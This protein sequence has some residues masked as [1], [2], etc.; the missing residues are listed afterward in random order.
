MRREHTKP[1]GQRR[2]MPQPPSAPYVNTHDAR[3][4]VA[5]R[6]Q[7]GYGYG[8][9][10][11]DGDDDGKGEGGERKTATRN[12]SIDAYNEAAYQV[13]WRKLRACFDP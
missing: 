11:G 2:S 9:G 12:E 8:D 10:K 4:A 13:G 3:A 6:K 5:T 7:P 1:E